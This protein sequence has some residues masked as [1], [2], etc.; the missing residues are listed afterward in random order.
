MKFDFYRFFLIIFYTL[1][2]SADANSAGLTLQPLQSPVNIES[3]EG[4]LVLSLDVKTQTT[5]IYLAPLP[6][7]NIRGKDY[8]GAQT[9]E[10]NTPSQGFVYVVLPAGTYQ[11]TTIEIP[12]FNLP[13][14]L[15]R[16]DDER[17]RLIVEPG[18][19]AYAGHLAIDKLRSEHS[20]KVELHNRGFE[21][22]PQILS[23]LAP[24]LKSMEKING[25]AMRDPAQ[26]N[27]L[28]S[29]QKSTADIKS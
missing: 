22:W 19:I 11:I 27:L 10:L 24:A 9:I 18:S 21:Q 1:L 26:E 29:L 17:W 12:Y 23:Q 16:E 14:S 6:L 15:G 25:R 2:V 8:A 20:V 3:N 13:Y 4:L 5:K 7:R 28:K